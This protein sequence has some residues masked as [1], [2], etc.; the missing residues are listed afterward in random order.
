MRYKVILMNIVNGIIEHIV[1]TSNEDSAR[2]IC[3]GIYGDRF[4]VIEVEEI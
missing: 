3:E 2:F 4:R 1:N